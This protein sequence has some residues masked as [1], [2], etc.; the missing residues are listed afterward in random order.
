MNETPEDGPWRCSR[1]L[2]VGFVYETADGRDCVRHCA[3]HPGAPRDPV[4][5]I[6]ACRI[7]ATHRDCTLASFRG[8]T[9]T[10]VDAYRDVI[11][12]YELFP[13]KGKK[14][15]HGMVFWGASGTGKTHLAVGLL[16]ELIANKG[17]TGCFW[18]FAQ[19]LLAM[20]RSYDA[21]TG[22]AELTPLESAMQADVLVLD[23]LASR[24]MPDW[25]MNTLFEIINTRYKEQRSTI[26]TTL[27]EDV[28]R[29]TA[30][31]AHGLTRNE[32]LIE[33]IGQPS[34]SRL[35]EMCTFVPMQS[36][37]ERRAQRK[38]RSPST[39]RGMRRERKGD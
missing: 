34:R 28:D 30:R 5:P 3:C 21:S 39:L 20:T 11:G 7:P 13:Y 10:L 17:I 8:S 31:N 22:Y 38:P 1:C 29:D 6:D 36:E 37:D 23:D 15:G 25:A 14:A 32:Y 19:L 12:Y 33:R 16:K 27:Y 26:V 9:S 24:R 2:D 35:V 4:D 18:N